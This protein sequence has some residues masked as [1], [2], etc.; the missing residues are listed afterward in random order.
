MS[1]RWDFVDYEGISN[2]YKRRRIR[3]LSR[4]D[5]LL[6]HLR[7]HDYVVVL[8]PA[9]SEKT[10]LLYDL[11]E[12]ANDDGRFTPVIVNLW[13]ARTGD[14]AQFYQS[15]VQLI[16][17][18]SSLS[19]PCSDRGDD[20]V[21]RIAT[22]RD[23]QRF[24]N[25]CVEQQSKHFLLMF[26]HLQALPHDLIQQLISILRSAYMERRPE[27]RCS[28][29]V[30][31]AGGMSLADLSLGLASPLNMTKLV[32]QAQLT[33]QQTIEL[34]IQNF[35]A[36]TTAY[37][38][39]ALDRIAFWADGDYY[40]T[41]RLVGECRLA[42]QGYRR[43]RV[44]SS[45]IEQVARRVIERGVSESPFR[46]AVQVI[47]DDP[48]TVLDILQLL[49]QDSLPRNRSNQSLLRGGLERLQL[50]G[51]V[52]LEGDVY[53]FKNAL[54][55]TVLA[56]HFTPAQ[57]G[58]VLRM[59][60]RWAEAIEHLSVNLPQER[61]RSERS[62]LLEA[63]VQSIYAAED[64]KT[65]YAALLDGM[66]RGFGLSNICIY[67]ALV[68]RGKLALVQ[69]DL[70][71]T[72]LPKELDLDDPDRVEVQTFRSGE[73]ALRGEE[74]DRRLVVRLVPERRPIGLVTVEHYYSTHSEQHGVPPELPDL[75]RFLR[76][77]AGA[78]EDVIFRSAFR[79][80]GQAVLSARSGQ[81]NL[82]RVLQ[83]VVNAVGSD[84]GMLYLMEEHAQRLIFSAQAGRVSD[85]PTSAAPVVALTEKKH[86]AVRCLLENTLQQARSFGSRDHRIYLPLRAANQQL[87]VL[88]LAYDA[89]R[90]HR[91]SG[92][93]Q[94]LLVTFADQLSIA[95]HNVQLLQRTN[96]ELEAKVREE[97]ELRRKLEWMRS[98]ELAEVAQ[99]LVHRL[100]HAGD[101]L[102]Y[103]ERA[104]A[105][106]QESLPGSV[107]P[108]Q[109]ADEK[110]G[111]DSGSAPGLDQQLVNYQ[112]QLVR[113]LEH[114]EKRFLQ[115]SDLMPALRNVAKLR[116]ME[117]GVL[118]LRTVIDQALD[119][120][121]RI[122]PIHVHWSRPAEAILME[123]DATL[124]QDAIFSILENACEAMRKGGQLTITLQPEQEGQAC[125][126]VVDTGHGIDE[127]I[128]HRIFEPGFTTR[129]SSD[130]RVPRG[131]GLFVCRAVLRRHRG[132]V[133][134]LSSSAEGST[135]IC[136]LPLI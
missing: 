87:G 88:M 121:G 22:A 38:S 105:T 24:L 82:E 122:D 110:A 83:I 10:Q 13:Q 85:R 124:L 33:V 103:L 18:T 12:A 4:V 5:T 66:R 65:A 35:A 80:I 29:D 128:R 11:G 6:G 67:Q 136:C 91:L 125:V 90:E 84:Q 73:Y 134:L 71:A 75:L 23:F 30:V 8:G 133:E 72:P 123:G 129:Q 131:H 127:G 54:Y 36:T 2:S 58:H 102:L 126:S 44:T 27:R 25:H 37:S 76:H 62:N 41:P 64:L 135:F 39:N 99:A 117:Q 118:D 9:H 40:L 63:I 49:K 28:L 70:E 52:V 32:F 74:K 60:G 77:A 1:E 79:D 47:E 98:N 20:S 59:N 46:Q 57:V 115:I 26:D 45:V 15:M 56:E 68:G 108:A 50:S 100:G 78:I 116:E 96:D 31:V 95:V 120:L 34:A 106:I 93:E 107:G 3:H 114:V 89:A 109:L 132:N 94:K 112:A 19:K 7:R 16:C 55:R 130:P 86:P 101:V 111:S 17:R 14:D 51:A 21:G 104:R 61:L 48:D 92:E 119:R 69:T 81:S 97:Q 43:N 113:Y 53:R 42:V